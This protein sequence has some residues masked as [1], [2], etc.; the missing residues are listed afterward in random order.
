MAFRASF[1]KR[2]TLPL[3]LLGAQSKSYIFDLREQ[4]G[5]ASCQYPKSNH[6]LHRLAA[7]SFFLIRRA[8]HCPLFML[9]SLN[10]REFYPVYAKYRV[11]G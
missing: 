8:F 2:S 1:S 5:S 9:H 6:K 10:E 3:D 7:P 4:S 11:N